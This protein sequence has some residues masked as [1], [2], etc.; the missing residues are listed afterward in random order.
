MT[1]M[2]RGSVKIGS[3]NPFDSPLIDVGFLTHPFDLA[4]L[5]E[6]IRALKRFYANSAFSSFIATPL[7][8]DPDL[9]PEAD[10][11][12]F[13]KAVTMSTLHG[14]GTASMSAVNAPNGVVNPDLKVKGVNGLSIA[15]ASVIVSV[16]DYTYSSTI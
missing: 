10:Y 16:S 8:P 9:M 5:K 3:N 2:S 1:P 7:G 13:T 12:A 11:D 6:G 4:C 14:V 15:D